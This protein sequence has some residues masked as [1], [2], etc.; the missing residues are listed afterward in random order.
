MQGVWPFEQCC[1]NQNCVSV[2][3]YFCG[4]AFIRRGCVFPGSGANSVL[5][6]SPQYCQ[7][8][9]PDILLNIGYAWAWIL[10][11][12]VLL[13][14]LRFKLRKWKLPAHHSVHK[15]QRLL[16][17]CY[18]WAADECGDHRVTIAWIIS[19]I[20]DIRALITREKTD[21]AADRAA[22]EL[23]RSAW[24]MAVSQLC[25]M[26]FEMRTSLLALG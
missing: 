20:A 9:R 3:I 4:F 24:W 12:S 21:F 10:F 14:R 6:Y 22:A 18:W 13:I 25:Q 2:Q 19:S 17:V 8:F 5:I 1:A 15:V 23:D 26:M 16:C 11:A 7:L